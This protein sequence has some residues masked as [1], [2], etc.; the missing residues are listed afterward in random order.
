MSKFQVIGQRLPLKDAEEKAIGNAAYGADIVLPKM[1]YG[2]ILRSPL[3]HAR[4]LNIDTSL[5]RNL[6]GVRA[7][8]TAQDAPDTRFGPMIGDE[9][10]LAKDEVFYIGDEVAAVAA[11]DEDAAAEALNLIKVDYEALP[12]VFDPVDAL[13]EGA[14]L[15]RRDIGSN[16]CYRI[17]IARGDVERGFDQSLIVEEDTYTL[18]HQYQAYIE[19]NA[20][21]AAWEGG[22]LTMWAPIQTPFLISKIICEA[23][24]IHRGMFRI[25]QTQVGGGFGGKQYQR[26][27]PIAAALALAAEVP[28]QIVL[29][30]EEDFQAGLPRVPMIIRL[31]MGANASGRITAKEV[32]IVA[33]NGAY[34]MMG[35]AIV[36]VAANRVDS[37]YRFEN[38]KVT[39]KLVYTNK[40]ATSCFRGFGN[41]QSH[42]AVESMM[43]VLAEKLGMD[44]KDI[45][46]R[47]AT[48]T[49]DVTA[50]G[51]HIDSCGLTETIEKA[52]SIAEWDQ[53]R[54][55]LKGK[56]RG[57]GM[58]CGLH[59]S[60]NS[61]AAPMS[62]G[63]YAQ[64]RVHEGGTVH[65]KTSEGDIGQGANAIFAQMVAE[66]LGVPY[67]KVFVDQLDT[68]AS[69]FGIGALASRVTVLGGGAVRSAVIDTKKRLVEA[70]S[71][72]WGCSVDDI[73]FVD[74]KLVNL[75]TEDTLDIE[76]AALAYI[77]M[78]GGSR[79]LGEGR[80][81][82]EGVVRP[83]K[84]KFGN[85]SLA[86]SFATQ[87][88]EVEVDV[89]TGKLSVNKLFAV[90]DSGLAINP[91]TA[92]GQVEGGMLMGMWYAIGEEYKFTDGRVMNPN[93]TDYAVPSIYD[94]PEMETIFLELPDPNGPY[95]AKSVGEIAMVPTAA[96][97]ANAVY[98]AIGIRFTKLPITPERV[99]QAIKENR[100]LSQR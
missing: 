15:A 68:D 98:D 11:I 60:G 69:Y 72:R 39:G 54:G 17:D 88:A 100:A 36:D 31:K 61:A 34:A 3:A 38:L 53:K 22:R 85:I 28:V 6:P 32:D 29:T 82:A 70:A 7:V 24:N 37:L 90:H 95:G 47:N 80:Y 73:H 55:L 58:A 10:I 63:S 89:E 59:V 50:H 19:T 81:R 12:A 52:A 56:H 42:F 14:P 93:F 26:V 57:I 76:Q 64:I 62:D 77:D 79:L 75:R 51:W 67:E 8:I 48:Q 43:D 65:I 27:G 84:T 46:L 18:P 35:P 99:L 2:R 74:G 91:M 86:Y 92:E 4:I 78:T 66:E 83:D 13:L 20:A 87:I 97:I 25:I 1:L 33:D 96:A 23:F 40:V 45:R 21:T 44:P 16:L 5:A 30:R 49:G 41:P 9:R 94:V 71:Y